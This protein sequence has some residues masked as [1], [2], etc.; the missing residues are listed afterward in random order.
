MAAVSE[1]T[2]PSQRGVARS[3]THFPPSFPNPSGTSLSA[4][5]GEKIKSV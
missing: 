5:T 3:N 1:L 4:Q 2:A